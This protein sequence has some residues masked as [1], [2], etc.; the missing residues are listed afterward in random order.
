M[1]KLKQIEILLVEDDPGDVELTLETMKQSKILMNVNVANDGIE[2]LD[3]LHRKGK[4]KN[5]PVPDLILLDLNLPLKD[6]SEVL[7][8]IKKDEKLRLIPVIVLT[9]S[10]AEEDIIKSYG[11]GANCYITKPVGFEQFVSVVRS[12][13]EFWFTVVRLPDGGNNV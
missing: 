10:K 4:F 11:L 9:T 2:A 3:Y 6:G 5:S 12:I 1:S 13:E 8:E 7:R